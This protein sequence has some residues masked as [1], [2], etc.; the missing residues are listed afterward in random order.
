M[1]KIRS[2][3][4]GS[5]QYWPRKRARR[6]YARIRSWGS[7]KEHK[8]L[9]FAGYKVGM[10]HLMIEDNYTHSPTK[11]KTV[12]MPVT[13]IECP[14][15]K[16]AGLLLYK[17]AP[18]GLRISH[19]LLANSLDKELGRK[20]ILPKKKVDKDAA[21]EDFDELRLLV[22]TQP[23]LTFIGK[24]KPEVFELALGGSKQEQLQFGKEKLGKEI[25]VTEVFNE[26]QQIDMHSV[27]KGKGTQGPVKRFGVAIRQH[28]S[29]KTKRGP[30]TLGGWMCNSSWRVAHAGQMGFHTRT[31]YNKWIIKIGEKEKINP[32]GGFVRYGLVKNPF[33]LVKG[34]VGGSKKRL[35]R[36]TI[37]KRPNNKIPTTAPAIQTISVR[38]QQ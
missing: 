28:K 18:S 21:T 25:S 22:Y 20:L 10:T 37:A 26:G 17:T 32:E 3:R 1:P 13:I 16:V 30:G 6:M 38:S 12:A 9:G 15:V 36:M 29:E 11:G 5:M 4:R 27:T 35:I 31:E 33:V 24:K 19:C 34:S 14:P 8:P 23:K 7:S 2:P